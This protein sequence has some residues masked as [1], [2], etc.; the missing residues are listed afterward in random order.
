MAA[1]Q[2][3]LADGRCRSPPLRRWP[4]GDRA[5][6][7]P[8]PRGWLAGILLAMKRMA[9]LVSMFLA[10]TACGASGST[11]GGPAGV[12]AAP[13]SVPATSPEATAG[14]GAAAPRPRADYATSADMARALGC[15]S[16]YKDLAP[17][18]TAK[19]TGD[20]VFLGGDVEL[21]VYPDAA[22]AA[23]AAQQARQAGPSFGVT[24]TSG[25]TWLA[26]ARGIPAEKVQA[27]LGGR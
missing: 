14:S 7:P 18:S 16:T 24:I 15:M 26:G 19:A 23:L 4:P 10:L 3:E 6:L 11:G 17:K 9:L 13:R 5:P 25:P 22:T 8:A 1:V 27:R 2:A 21:D 12:V 20:C